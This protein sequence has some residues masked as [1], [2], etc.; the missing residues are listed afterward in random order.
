MPTSGGALVKANWFNDLEV[1]D[2]GD[3]FAVEEKGL[4]IEIGD[5][6]ARV[7]RAI[8]KSLDKEGR[9]AAI[10]VTCAIKDREDTTCWACP[11]YRGDTR[12][13]I[14]PLCNLGREQER[15]STRLAVLVENRKDEEIVS[16]HREDHD[17]PVPATA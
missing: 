9:L 5:E 1:E 4:P 2:E 6:E 14:A 13:S 8:S 7:T 11:V 15:L 12:D 10:G 3:P 17:P 16:A